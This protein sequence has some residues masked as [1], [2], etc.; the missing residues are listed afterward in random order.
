[1]AFRHGPSMSLVSRFSL[2]KDAYTLEDYV[3]MA[4][5][6]QQLPE[7]LQILMGYFEAKNPHI[8]EEVQDSE[9]QSC[10]GS[11]ENDLH[12]ASAPERHVF[13]ILNMAKNVA[14]LFCRWRIAFLQKRLDKLVDSL[15]NLE[16]NFAGSF[17]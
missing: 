7:Q 14:Q 1:M 8:Y 9:D 5:S 17:V 4:Q 6:R 13:V 2:T 12:T 15:Y 11:E 3:Q 16:S 10:D